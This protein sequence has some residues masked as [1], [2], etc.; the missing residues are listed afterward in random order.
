MF[1]TQLLFSN[2]IYSLQVD[3]AK[4]LV[5]RQWL[6]NNGFKI[7]NYKTVKG[8]TTFTLRSWT[9]AG[10]AK[11]SAK[12]PANGVTV[13]TPAPTPVVDTTPEEFRVNSL[14]KEAFD[15][16]HQ[17]SDVVDSLSNPDL[18]RVFVKWGCWDFAKEEMRSGKSMQDILTSLISGIHWSG[19]EILEL[20]NRTEFSPADAPELTHRQIIAGG[21]PLLNAIEEGELTPVLMNNSLYTTKMSGKS[22]VIDCDHEDDVTDILAHLEL[23]NQRSL[24][25]VLQDPAT[26]QRAVTYIA[27][28]S[29]YFHTTRLR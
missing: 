6:F 3:P 18:K 1:A 28:V 25:I 15:E 2:N 20:L 14:D 10:M 12:Y 29:I 9:H 24:K 8:I 26:I 27:K 7:N 4:T 23:P 5:T 13:S 22:L 19:F 21:C 17:I 16:L 11:L